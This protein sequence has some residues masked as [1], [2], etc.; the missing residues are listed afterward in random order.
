M[1]AAVASV[2][3]TSSSSRTVCRGAAKRGKSTRS[4]SIG[5]CGTSA[6]QAT[7]PTE[8]SK[9][10]RREDARQNE[11][12]T[13]GPDTGMARKG[14]LAKRPFKRDTHDNAGVGA[15]VGAR[16]AMDQGNGSDN[17]NG[18]GDGNANGSASDEQDRSD[19]TER[20][21]F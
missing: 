16:E 11:G 17:V 19:A 2:Y 4:C 3:R 12:M 1:V 10:S 7:L 13:T 5:C 8:P 14:L 21:E 18:N 9:V 20:A 15:G 6:A